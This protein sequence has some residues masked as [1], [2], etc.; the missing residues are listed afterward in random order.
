MHRRSVLLTIESWRNF[1]RSIRVIKWQWM[2]WKPLLRVCYCPT[3]TFAHELFVIC[4]VAFLAWL[5]C[6]EHQSCEHLSHEGSSASPFEVRNGSQYLGSNTTRLLLPYKDL[7]AQTFGILACCVP[8]LA[9]MNRTSVLWTF[10]SWRNFRSSFRVIKGQSIPWKQL[11]TCFIAL[12]GPSRTNFWYFDL[13]MP[14]LATM[15]R[16]SALWNFE[17]WMNFCRSIRGNK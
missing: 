2:P 15:H 8:S 5:P 1:C 9:T 3:R 11:Y 10:E 7:R 4:P 14:S 6:T 16:T 12:Q 13:C 17:S